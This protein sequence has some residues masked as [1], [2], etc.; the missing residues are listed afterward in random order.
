MSV[1]ACPP[2]RGNRKGSVEKSVHFA[3][4]RFWRTMTAE[5]MA[6]AQAQLDRFSE[7]IAD[8]RPRPVAKLE[9][10]IGKDAVTALLAARERRRP[11]V[12]DLA[13]LERLRPLPAAC[14][15]ATIEAHN[16]V[17]P[18]GHRRCQDRLEGERPP[19]Q[20]LSR[21]SRRRLRRTGPGPPARPRARGLG[22]LQH[23]GAVQAQGQPTARRRGPG[24]GGEA[25]R[26]L[27]G[28]RGRRLTC[29]LPGPRRRHGP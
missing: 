13:G 21:G 22:C 23:R 1:I 29:L 19:R 11:T 4:R 15:P 16:T 6:Q 26:R 2:H 12:A 14:Y 3:T 9:E 24:R 5:T 8:R 28:R 25:P 10:L 17:G 18:S 20:P 27:R 7:R